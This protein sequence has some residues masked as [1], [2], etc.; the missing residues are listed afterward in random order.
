MLRKN[1]ESSTNSSERACVAS[2]VLAAEPVLEGE[3]QEMADVDDFGGLPAT[4]AEPST[5]G[6]SLPT[7][8]SSCPRRCR[9]SRRPRAHGTAAVGEHQQRLRAVALDRPRR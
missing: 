9:R 7:S 1:A 2:R 6:R 4:T 3:R 8:M 5:P